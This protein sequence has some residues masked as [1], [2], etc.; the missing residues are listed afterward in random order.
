MYA[1]A[2]SLLGF[3]LFALVVGWPTLLLYETAFCVDVFTGQNSML[4]ALLL[5]STSLLFGWQ[6]VAQAILVD[7][8]VRLSEGYHERYQLVSDYCRAGALSRW[9]QSW[10]GFTFSDEA[11]KQLAALSPTGKYMFCCEPHNPMVQHVALGFAAHGGTSMSTV[12]RTTLVVA[13]TLIRTIPVVREIMSLYGVIG[14]SRESIATALA[15]GYSLAIIPSG[16]VGKARALLDV[17]PPGFVYIYRRKKRLGFIKLAIEAG[18]SLV[19]VLEPNESRAYQLYNRHW[20]AWP[21][22]L[23]VGQR[24]LLPLLPITVYVGEPI[25]TVGFDASD[26]QAV[27]VLADLLYCRMRLLAPPGVYVVYRDYDE[28]D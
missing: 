10:V 20:Q 28:Y 15:H 1:L 11:Q 24:L 13:D 23:I 2:A 22:V 18:A 25:S 17:P 27:Q 4:R 5:L 19:P 21:F 3:T 14:R 26:P 6:L 8:Y 12:A 7:A 9:V 16:L